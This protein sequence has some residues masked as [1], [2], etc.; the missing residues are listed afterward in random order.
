MRNISEKNWREI[1]VLILCSIIFPPLRIACRLEDNVEK[2]GRGWQAGRQATDWNILWRI[3][4]A[5]WVT[6]AADIHSKY[7]LFFAFQ[8]QKWLRERASILR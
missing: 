4:F 5:C 7:V 2:Y 6:K 3:H 8:R 1:K